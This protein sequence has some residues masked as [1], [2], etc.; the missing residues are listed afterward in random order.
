MFNIEKHKKR[1]SKQVKEANKLTQSISVSEKE[2]KVKSPSEHN[3]NKKSKTISKF[4]PNKIK[5]QS[6][7][8]KP[9]S[10]NC[11]SNI[12]K[13]NFFFLMSFICNKHASPRKDIVYGVEYMI[14]LKYE[15]SFKAQ[16]GIVH[17]HDVQLDIPNEKL[18]KIL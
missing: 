7:K 11:L 4:E 10:E 13:E 12:E 1:K 6:L 8:P 15:L 9:I 16:T 5:L 18:Q 14:H 3:V 2:I 17:I